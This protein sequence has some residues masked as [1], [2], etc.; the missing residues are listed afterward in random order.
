MPRIARVVVPGLPHH[1]TQRGNRRL[2]TFFAD[3][4]YRKY[5]SIMA[6][7]CAQWNVEVWAYCLMPNH[8][9]LIV[10][11]STKESLAGAI[12]EAHR[13]YTY[14]LNMRNEW[15]GYLWQ[16]RFAS[17]PMDEAHL[18]MAARYVELNPV[19]AKLVNRPEQYPWSSAAAHLSG[20][21]DRLV[22]VKP[23]L[24]LFGDWNS[25][26]A[27][28]LPPKEAELLRKHERNGKPMG[29]PKFIA[30][31]EEQTGFT[32]APK[33]RGPKGPRKKS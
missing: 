20:R 27:L 22:K 1:I 6:K 28:G 29:S 26:L 25:Y 32:L 7:Q 24:E 9:H 10:V 33:K 31:M 4:D 21:D 17:F 5:I 19:R 12:G 15:S 8:A 3:D 23:L 2:Q 14:Q 18:Y 16:G 30:E 11:P 13:R